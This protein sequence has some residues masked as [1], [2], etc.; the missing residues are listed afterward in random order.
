MISL[1]LF[2]YARPD[3]SSFGLFAQLWVLGVH[4][5]IHPNCTHWTLRDGHT[6]RPQESLIGRL[7]NDWNWQYQVSAYYPSGAQMTAYRTV[8]G[9]QERLS[10]EAWAERQLEQAP[11]ALFG[12]EA[13]PAPV[14]VSRG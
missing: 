8:A 7:D 1:R 2:P 14:G 5:S 4:L 3:L 6:N 9:E 12:W 11:S 13:P 10:I